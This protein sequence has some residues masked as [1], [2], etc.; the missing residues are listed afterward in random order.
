MSPDR[1]PP[2]SPADWLAR[3]QSN[4]S[5][6]NQPKPDDVFWEDLCFDAQQAAEKALKA[7][8]IKKGIA[9]RFVHDI[10]E[11]ISLLKKA[12]IDIPKNVLDSVELTEFAVEAR[13]PGPF[14]AVTEEEAT[15]SIALAAAVVEWVTDKL[16]DKRI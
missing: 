6:A 1:K 9:F 4:L 10:G 11:L 15:R 5:R 16:S 3:A 2:G 12:S 7:L 8:L 13:Y 14:E